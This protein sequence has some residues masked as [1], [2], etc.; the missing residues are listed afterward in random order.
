MPNTKQ[1][2][3]LFDHE[4][5]PVAAHVE[6]RNPE[7]AI[8]LRDEKSRRGWVA[9]KNAFE[10]YPADGEDIDEALHAIGAL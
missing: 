6:D 3:L 2:A 9:G 4:I 8:L 7:L 1:H 10:V 5:E